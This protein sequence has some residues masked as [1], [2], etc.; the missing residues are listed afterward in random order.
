MKKFLAILLA[1]ATVTTISLT[2][3]NKKEDPA[4]DGDDWDN[5]FYNENK[6][7]SD[8]SGSS[9]TADNGENG[10][11]NTATWIDKN[12][13]V[14]V[15][16]N[17][18]QLREGPGKSYKSAKTVDFKT[19]LTRLQTNGTWDKVKL[20]DVEYY[21]MSALVSTNINDFEFDDLASPVNLTINT[22]KQI[23]LR[24]TPFVPDTEDNTLLQHNVKKSGLKPENVTAEKPLVK[25]A[26]SKSG[27]Y[28]KVTYDGTTYYIKG[29]K[30]VNEGTITDPSVSGGSTGG[31]SVVG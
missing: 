20:E 27:D 24:G 7:T 29:K 1:L 14:Y 26:V 19:A 17:G 2:A 10:G 3:C 11:A 9:D 16:M 4:D 8:T 21:V 25:V 13:T 6:D 5:D 23:N 31:G 12:D 22:G 30:L 18:T 15:G 28:Y